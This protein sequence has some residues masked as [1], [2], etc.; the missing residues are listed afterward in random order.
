MDKVVQHFG[1]GEIV[2]PEG[3][4][5]DRIYRILS[6]EVL[7]CKKSPRGKII[8]ITKLTAGEIFG[9]MYLFDSNGD[10]SASVLATTDL[11]VEVFFEEDI[12]AELQDAPEEIRQML[13]AFTN[14]LRQTTG[15]FA[16]LF[17]E[18]MIVEMP[19][20]TMKVLDGR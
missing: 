14:R 8:P 12:Q 11:K 18:K 6:G 4:K 3:S 20:G 15:S 2:F 7:I 10:R 13:T 17:K 19:D 16:G 5:G 9:E 1:K